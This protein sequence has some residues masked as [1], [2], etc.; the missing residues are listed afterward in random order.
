[1]K[2]AV[3]HT[4][5]NIP[6]YEEFP[7]PVPG[8][9]EVLVEVA[10]A[11]LKSV[12][13][14]M[15]AGSHYASPRVLPAVCGLDGVGRLPSGERIY[16]GGVR[17]PNGA[18]SER[19]AI[20]RVFAFP[21]PPELSDEDA[22]ALPNPG[23]SAWLSLSYRARLKP[24]ENVLILGATAVTGRMA[25]Q[26]AKLLGAG[27][28]VAAGRNPE[29]LARLTELGADSTLRL[30]V[31]DDELRQS[32]LDQ[33]LKSAFHVVL[34][35]LWGR[36]AQLFLETLTKKEFAAVEQETRFVQ[37]GES[38]GPLISLPA[39][40]LR[41]AAVT[42]LGTA[43]VPPHEILFTSLNDVLQHGASGKLRIATERVALCD[44]ENTWNRNIPGRRIVFIP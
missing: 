20:R 8:D 38:A 4:L 10:A 24:D 19:T 23:V 28:V 18:M 35:Y 16:F 21:V 32:F 36:P 43:G 22:A 3:L 14:Q 1:M 31:A 40:V 26:I 37:V 27:R 6:R 13:R 42:I 5:G 39:A 33:S 12:D 17:P 2:A 41:S 30:D 34:D 44:V 11:S 15:A 7:D 9:G 25:V 29:I